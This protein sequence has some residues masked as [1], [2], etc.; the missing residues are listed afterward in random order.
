MDLRRASR[1]VLDIDL[2]DNGQLIGQSVET[3]DGWEEAIAL[4]E[5]IEREYT[6]EGN[7]LIATNRFQPAELWLAAYWSKYLDG[8]SPD[9]IVSCDVRQGLIFNVKPA[10]LYAFGLPAAAVSVCLWHDE[11]ERVIRGTIRLRGHL[12]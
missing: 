12:S 7:T 4:R 2:D 1:F 5:K 8:V 9:A 10:E 3:L 11:S 6:V